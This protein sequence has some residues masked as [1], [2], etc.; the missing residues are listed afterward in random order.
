MVK[1]QN[2]RIVQHRRN[3]RCRS[4]AQIRVSD[5][6]KTVNFDRRKKAEPDER[7]HHGRRPRRLKPDA[8]TARADGLIYGDTRL[9]NGV[10]E[11]DAVIVLVLLG[12]PVFWFY[13]ARRIVRKTDWY[14]RRHQ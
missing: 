2:S 5:L 7:P 8:T 9:R 11:M 4:K 1:G 3:G 13:V 12:V 14:R 10:S 6:G